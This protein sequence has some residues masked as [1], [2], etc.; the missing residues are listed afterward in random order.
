M[1]G[2]VKV[3]CVQAEPVAFEREATIDK[4]EKLVAEVAGAGARLA[5]FPETFIPVYPS[6]RWVRY[7]AGWSG[8]DSGDASDVFARL[9]QQSVTI[10]GP[11]SDRLAEIVGSLAEFASR[12]SLNWT[13]ATATPAARR[14]PT[15]TSRR[16]LR[17]ARRG[18]A[19]PTGFREAKCPNPS[20]ASRSDTATGVASLLCA[21]GASSSSR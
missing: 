14:R 5:L 7:L 3:A 10:P 18:W 21:A 16:F 19:A 20:C 4:L 8:D 9:A 1:E 6:N 11:D 17:R 12:P 13:A 2:V 15:T